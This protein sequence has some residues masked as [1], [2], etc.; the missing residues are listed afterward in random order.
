MKSCPKNWDG[1]SKGM[2]SQAAVLGVMYIY[3][4]SEGKV[5]IKNVCEKLVKSFE[6]SHFGHNSS[7]S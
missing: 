4:T 5:R 1:S 2:E 7:E 6:N 3:D